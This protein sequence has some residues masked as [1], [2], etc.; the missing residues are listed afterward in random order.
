MVTMKTT[1]A[2]TV[3]KTQNRNRS[4]RLIVVRMS[5]VKDSKII[6]EWTP[7]IEE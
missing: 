1:Q 2:S 5:A 6:Q 7:N 4:A 3:D